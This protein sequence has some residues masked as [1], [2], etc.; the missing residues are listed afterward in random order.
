MTLEG[1]VVFLTGGTSG[2]GRETVL[3][4]TRAGAHVAFAGRREEEGQ[5]VAREAEAARGQ[6]LPLVL[7]VSVPADVEH[8]IARTVERFGQLD[9]LIANAAV[10][11][12]IVRIDQ[13]SV[14]DMD[15]LIA[16]DFKGV[17]HVAHFGLPHL[18]KSGGSMVFV[19]SFWSVLGGVG[20]SAYSSAKGAINALTRQLAV[21]LGPQGVR[22]NTV[23]SGGVDTPQYQRFTHGR[24][25]TSYMKNNVPLERVGQP[26]ELA[27]AI[28]WLASDDASYVTG[29]CLGV[30][31]G[32]SIKMSTVS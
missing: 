31:G 22:V 12:Q 26:D 13:M 1:K 8:G 7:D 9:I 3:Q 16:I 6:V 24:D 19:S 10:E 20:L 28:L 17:W 18:K 27:R 21:E 15:R 30:D 25:M 32:A 29:Q 11:Q 4:F 2:I 23:V 5:A 14:E